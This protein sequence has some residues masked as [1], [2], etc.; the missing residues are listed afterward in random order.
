MP[1]IF[2]KQEDNHTSKTSSSP[3]HTGKSLPAVPA[4]QKKE[5]NTGLPDNLKS[6]VEQLSGLAMDDVKVHYNSAQP[7]QLN[8]LA[9]AQG[10]D[11]HVAPGQE[12]HLP[13]EAWHVAQQKQGRV[14]ATMQMKEGTPVNDDAGLE[15]EADS[16]GAKAAQLKTDDTIQPGSNGKINTTTAPVQRALKIKKKAITERLLEQQ[17]ITDVKVVAVIKEF[18]TT[19]EHVFD[20]WDEIKAAA[21]KILEERENAEPE[22]PTAFGTDFK[23]DKATVDSVMRSLAM[24][25]PKGFVATNTLASYAIK[26]VDNEVDYH[27]S[28]TFDPTGQVATG[29]HYAIR[30]ISAGARK[31]AV[32]YRF[33]AVTRDEATK[34]L[35]AT[36]SGAAGEG[37]PTE[38]DP[39]KAAHDIT[40]EDESKLTQ[41]IGFL[42]SKLIR[43]EA[44]AARAAAEAA[45][46][47]GGGGKAKGGKAK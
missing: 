35:S 21:A 45:A 30:D 23:L 43:K 36:F 27:I 3:T 11:I 13:H 26:Y 15:A 28:W 39:I 42:S 10:T 20:D 32:L 5:N 4:L 1:G 22:A 19:G 9:Y 37:L 7:A 44:D 33:Y 46:A 24:A 8:A 12:Q 14:Q 16:M 47:K 31:K 41:A 38:I 29:V 34:V 17:R 2:A 18:I 6:G 25:P 40:F